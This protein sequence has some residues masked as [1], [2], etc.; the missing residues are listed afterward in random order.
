[1][2]I[3]AKF[4]LVLARERRGSSLINFAYFAKDFIKKVWMRDGCSAPEE[5]NVYSTAAES[6]GQSPVGAAYDP[7]RNAAPTELDSKIRE[8]VPTNIPLLTELSAKD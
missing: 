8:R 4:L 2:P 7:G 6:N 5:R 3:K 1:M